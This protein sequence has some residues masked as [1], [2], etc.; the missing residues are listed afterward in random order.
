M[1]EEIGLES[2]NIFILYESWLD[3]CGKQQSWNSETENNILTWAFQKFH[4]FNIMLHNFVLIWWIVLVF[5]KS[6]NC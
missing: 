1:S 4:Y 5:Y 6:A 3:M 2:W